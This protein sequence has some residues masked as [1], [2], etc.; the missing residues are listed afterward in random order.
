MSKIDIWQWAVY[1]L[2]IVSYLIG[3]AR[4][5][6]SLP[7]GI[8]ALLA[9]REVMELVAQGIAIAASLDGKS[10]EEKRECVREWAKSELHE[11]LGER[12]PDSAINYLIEHIIVSRKKV[13]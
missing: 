1:L 7:K 3:V 13:R 9:N 10:D 6:I 12:L 11:L 8:R 4:S 2:P 5:R